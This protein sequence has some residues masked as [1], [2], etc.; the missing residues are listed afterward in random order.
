MLPTRYHRF[1]TVLSSTAYLCTNKQAGGKNVDARSLTSDKWSS[2]IWSSQLPDAWNGMIPLYDIDRICM[3]TWT[4]VY[5]DLISNITVD[6]NI[7]EGNAVECNVK[8]RLLRLSAYWLITAMRIA[9]SP[10]VNK[11]ARNEVST[12]AFVVAVYAIRNGYTCVIEMA[13]PHPILFSFPTIHTLHVD[14]NTKSMFVSIRF[15]CEK[16]MSHV[17]GDRLARF[18][19]RWYFRLL[20]HAQMLGYYR[21]LWEEQMNTLVRISLPNRHHRLRLHCDGLTTLRYVD[22]SEECQNDNH[23]GRETSTCLDTILI[24]WWRPWCQQRS[25]ARAIDGEQVSTY[26]FVGQY[27]CPRFF[28]DL[29]NL[30]Q[31]IV[32]FDT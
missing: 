13:W 10:V 7:G 6:G 2:H 14:K 29:R 19:G 31:I 22:I 5:T 3:S 16:W 27:S 32:L 20:L 26:A 28:Q 24:G 12:Y 8:Q 4:L 18:H 15:F 11:S 17:I 23:R 25:E 9:A 30:V 1:A 21:T